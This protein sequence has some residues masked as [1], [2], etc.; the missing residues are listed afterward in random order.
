MTDSQEQEA[1]KRP[2]NL[3]K[4][5]THMGVIALSFLVVA[6]VAGIFWIGDYFVR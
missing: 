5:Q 4:G 6:V 2:A 3:K 1:Q